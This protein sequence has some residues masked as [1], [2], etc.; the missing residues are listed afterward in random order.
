[1]LIKIDGI[2]AR[3]SSPLTHEESASG[4][5]ER[6]KK[7]ILSFFEDLRDDVAGGRPI[8]YIGIARSLDTWG[9]DGGNL[10]NEIIEV[11]A[12]LNS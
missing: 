5:T 3:L 10:Y 1:M 4:W 12:K 6:S 8:A 9:V 2:I 11:A 7:A